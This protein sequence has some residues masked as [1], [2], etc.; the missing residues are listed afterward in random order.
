MPDGSF[1]SVVRR[2]SD[3]IIGSSLGKGIRPFVSR[4]ISVARDPDHGDTPAGGHLLD[5]GDIGVVTGPRIDVNDR[6]A[7]VTKNRGTGIGNPVLE[8]FTDGK[9]FGSV[10]RGAGSDD[11]CELPCLGAGLSEVRVSCQSVLEGA[12]SVDPAGGIST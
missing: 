2:K 7:V 5:G 1:L 11:L 3:C 6:G 4:Y 8:G 12:V 10:D 9:Q